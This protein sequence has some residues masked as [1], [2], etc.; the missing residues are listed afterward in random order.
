MDARSKKLLKRLIATPMPR[1][2]YLLSFVLSRLLLLVAEVGSAVG[3]RRFGFH[4]SQ[5]AVRCWIS[6]CFAFWVRSLSALWGC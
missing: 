5:F 4:V 1:S 3:V 6:P 2:Y